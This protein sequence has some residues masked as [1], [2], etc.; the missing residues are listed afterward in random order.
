MDSATRVRLLVR[1]F[2]LFSAEL[3][4][5]APESDPAQLTYVLVG[6]TAIFSQAAEFS[7]V[8]GQDSRDPAAVESHV[9]L[10]VRLLLPGSC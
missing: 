5:L 4:Q 2:L 1:E 10:V 6:A 3:P 7:L 9:D 8:T